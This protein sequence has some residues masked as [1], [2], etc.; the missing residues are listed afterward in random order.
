M[1]KTII[2][3]LSNTLETV[4]R[5]IAFCVS[6]SVA[7]VMPGLNVNGIG[8]IGLPISEAQAQELI[9]VCHQ[10]PYGKGEQTLVDTSVR[11][12]WALDPQHF[13]LTNPKWPDFIQSR[14]THVQEQLGL[15]DQDLTYHL[16]QLLVYEPGSFF[17]PHQDGEKLDGMVGTLVVVLPS[18]YEGGELIVRH[19]GHEETIDFSGPEC[20]FNLHL[21]AFYAD[22]EHEIK[23]VRTGYRISLVYNITLAR[24]KKTIR[25]PQYSSQTAKITKLL[26]RWQLK[27]KPEKLV[28]RLEHEY[29]E[30]GLTPDRLKGTDRARAQALFAAA[31]QA[32]CRA[33]LALLTL[34]ELG[35]AECD[36]D[37]GGYDSR[38]SEPDDYTMGEVYDQSL[39]ANHWTDA[40]GNPIDFGE[41]AIEEEEIVSTIDLTDVDPEEEFEGYTGN[42]GM[43]LQRWYRH[44][45]IV[46][47][48]DS[49]HFEILS[50]AGIESAIAGLQQM[51][52]KWRNQ[53]TDNELKGECIQFAQTIMARWPKRE[54]NYSQHAEDG[55]GCNMLSILD[56]LDDPELIATYIGDILVRDAGEQPERSLAGLCKRRSW[57][58]YQKQL[59][60]LIKNTTNSTIT[61]NFI[62]L[63]SFCICK[64]KHPDRLSLCKGLVAHA[65]PALKRLDG[66]KED[67][68]RWRGNAF[69]R[70]QLVT[71]LF[72]SLHAV[73]AID[74]LVELVDHIVNLPEKYDLTT[75]QIPTVFEL[76]TWM[77]NISGPECTSLCSWLDACHRELGSRTEHEPQPPSNWRRPAKLSCSYSDCSE[78]SYFLNSPNEAT[79]RFRIRKDRR[80][81][82]HQII[83][84]HQCDTTHETER[85]GSPQTLVC[86]KTNAT[87]ERL[88]K[89]YKLDCQNLTKIAEIQ[90]R[91][92]TFRTR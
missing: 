41:L 10:A 53:T 18:I 73:H 67:D 76:A 38:Y 87:Y 46:L 78:L 69:D 39:T 86:H 25:A 84:R 29:T 63:E 74:L 49:R 13:T 83:E 47:W 19:C 88:V 9:R 62:I 20:A 4:D 79:H 21:A 14:L 30:K 15:E 72:K 81:H 82:L 33:Y 90:G 43:E 23:P 54:V 55:N 2:Q 56:A 92:R 48:L 28:I 6:E 60:R 3:E 61:R 64:D 45:A 5:P 52:E 50:D 58:T 35:E 22:C 27:D 16:Y 11:R 57:L 59:T 40:D 42:A 66:T 65:L 7:V 71:S 1:A 75:V 26:Q 44:G 80:Q 8:T 17:L 34:Y 12:V 70:K 36:D 85:R 24:S 89:A 32:K 31:P 77:E 37:Y 51:V 91:L 68:Y